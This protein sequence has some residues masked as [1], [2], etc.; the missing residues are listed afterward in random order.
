MR[1]LVVEDDPDVAA[2][3]RAGLQAAGLIVDIAPD[4]RAPLDLDR[5]DQLDRFGDAGPGLG[6]LGM[7]DDDHACDGRP[8]TKPAV[9]F[10]YGGHL[11]NALHVHQ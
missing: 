5:A 3:I 11:G 1:A 2:D 9:L 7:L 10:R 6:K 4:G 8:E